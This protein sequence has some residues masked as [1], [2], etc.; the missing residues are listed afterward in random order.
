ML[1][2]P[3]PRCFDHHFCCCGI[4]VVCLTFLCQRYWVS[5]RTL[6]V[7]THEA[8]DVSVYVLVSL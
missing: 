3:T 4:P 5:K 8:P 6:I 7:P 1:S 2:F